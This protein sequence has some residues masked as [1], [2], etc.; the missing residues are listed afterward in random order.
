MSRPSKPPQEPVIVSLGPFDLMRPIGR[1]G[2]AE[3][4]LALHQTTRTEVAIKVVGGDTTRH[5]RWL[6]RFRNEIRAVA[7]LNHPGI[8]HVDDFG[9]IPGEAER[10]SGGRL[11]AG[12]PYL[13]M[14]LVPGGSL[15][16]LTGR[17]RWARLRTVLLRLLDALAHAHARGLIHRDI[18][19]GNVL[20]DG[21]IIKLA[22]FGL[23]HQVE[24]G[25]HHRDEVGVSGTPA[26]MAPEQWESRWRDYGPWT[27]LYGV[28][29]LAWALATG[30][31]PFRGLGDITDLRE[32]H[33]WEKPP[34]LRPRQSVPA[35]FERWLRGLLEK[36]PSRRF[37]RAADAAWAL[38]DL[39]E[40]LA[41]EDA[42]EVFNALQT[43][44]E[45]GAISRSLMTDPGISVH[46]DGIPT[47]LTL[48]PVGTFLETHWAVV[49]PPDREAGEGGP[50]SA[51]EARE[52]ARPG[53][54]TAPMPRS[55][56]GSADLLPSR[57]LPGAGLRLYGFRTIPVVGREE[58]K[59]QLWESLVQ[60]HTERRPR[61]VVLTGPAGCGKSRLARWLCERAHEVGGATVVR[62]SHGPI[63]GP[64][65][66]LGPALRRFLHL[67]GLDRDG[68]FARMREV[69]RREGVNDLYEWAALTELVS[70]RQG[71]RASGA[72]AV[73]FAD[74]GERFLILRRFLTRL[75]DERPVVLWIDDAHWAS[76]DLRFVEHLLTTA[77]DLPVFV[78][79]TV[80]DDVLPTRPLEFE[81][82]RSIKAHE[83]TTTLPIGPLPHTEWRDL[84][85]QILVLEGDL[86]ARVEERTAGN[87]LFAVQLVAD[88]VQRGI[89]EPGPV[90][91]RLPKGMEAPLPDDLRQVWVERM[92]RILDGL[93]ESD[94][95]AVQ[96]AAVLG[97]EVD[98]REWRE[99]CARAQVTPSAQ[100]L[101]RLQAGRLFAASEHGGEVGWSFA[102]GMLRETNER[103]AEDAG[104]LAELHLICA[105]MLAERHGPG[106]DE[107]TGRHLL[108]AAEY[109]KA[110]R[111]LLDGATRRREHGE[112][113]HAELLLNEREDALRALDVSEDDA[114]WVQGWILRASLEVERHRLDRAETLA[115]R[116]QQVAQDQHLQG[117]DG[118][119]SHV[120]G[121][122]ACLEGDLDRAFEHLGKAA[123]LARQS[124]DRQLGAACHAGQGMVY[125]LENKLDDA[126]EFCRRARREY[127]AT[128]ESMG[129]A[130]MSLQLSSIALRAGRRSEA[131]KHI[132]DAL[133]AFESLG[134]RNSVALCITQ[135][136]V[137]ERA[138]GDRV[139]AERSLRE[140]LALYRELGTDGYLVPLV[141]LAVVLLEQWE[142]R[143]A[144]ALLEDAI[145]ALERVGGWSSLGALQILLLPAVAL[146]GDWE[147]FDRLLPEADVLITSTGIVHEDIP[148]M[149]RQ[150]AEIARHGRQPDRAGRAYAL[151]LAQYHALGDLQ[152]VAR[153]RAAMHGLFAE[154]VEAQPAR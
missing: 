12:S 97:Q 58:D 16:S 132:A 51:T 11:R 36:D 91:F 76:E 79:L 3:V 14:E 32:Q 124:D 146:D 116:A 141:Q 96:L 13:V 151:A 45:M 48:P 21:R 66:G 121:R 111:P 49:L 149:A 135:R 139:V 9:E 10:L 26:Y 41:S 95:V 130:S 82:L 19:P 154:V 153:T 57:L 88:W 78:V 40:D 53:V 20:G 39:P 35:G 92:R 64:T 103:M 63:E 69:L 138:Q 144:R 60:V 18:T 110:L 118:W 29:C 127:A 143:E 147:E 84:V 38:L 117:L 80:R 90:G 6:A 145:E 50:P 129:A 62:A 55:W 123:R 75:C 115:S 105:T 56:Q 113:R 30:L 112:F 31:P 152:E 126:A 83:H 98:D 150:A 47:D 4:W 34:P 125:L 67:E 109:D 101:E 27:D 86:A 87:P 44:P 119:A 142:H 71:V 7:G 106:V 107:R 108:A 1:G 89:L 24:S 102:H 72:T 59:N 42:D 68:T 8:V 128:G 43:D 77:R 133:A 131:A 70:P 94:A 140:A 54:H 46:P 137:I 15:K 85:R 2:M 5:H 33:L 74:P 23:S 73:H 28:G 104:R 65:H 17:F 81:L 37:R 99:A 93:P 61:A 120:L 100:L 25:S 22:D 134:A 148:A 52:D 136:G 114:R 122:I